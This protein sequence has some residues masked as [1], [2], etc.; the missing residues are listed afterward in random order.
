MALVVWQSFE[1]ETFVEAAAKLAATEPL[2]SSAVLGDD[3][4][5]SEWLSENGQLMLMLEKHC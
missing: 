2:L 1:T 3:V 5:A 4:V